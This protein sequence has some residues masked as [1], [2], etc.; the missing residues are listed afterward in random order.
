MSDKQSHV[1]VVGDVCTCEYEG[2]AGGLL[3]VVTEVFHDSV[4]SIHL[5]TSLKIKPI[6]GFFQDTKNRKTRTI[7]AV[8]CTPRSLI[9]LGT[10]YVQLGHFISSL[11]LNRSK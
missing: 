3:Y 7:G 6:W 4:A 11:A 8:W 10:E 2:I 5:A 1:W 9:E